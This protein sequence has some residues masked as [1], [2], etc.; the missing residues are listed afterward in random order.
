MPK[1]KKGALGHS[2]YS[3]GNFSEGNLGTISAHRILAAPMPIIKSE[4]TPA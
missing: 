3:E 4:A 1:D 2:S